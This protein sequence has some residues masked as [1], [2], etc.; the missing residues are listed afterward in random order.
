MGAFIKGILVLLIAYYLIT[1]V[2]RFFAGMFTG[3]NSQQT[4]NSS[5]AQTRQTRSQQRESTT[6]SGN[7]FIK[8]PVNKDKDASDF[9][10]GEYVDYEEIK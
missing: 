7:I 10:G 6:R 3:Q 4:T 8:K 1:K 2:G 5:R 9:K